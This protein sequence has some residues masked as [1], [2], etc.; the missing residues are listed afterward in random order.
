MEGN[1]DFLLEFPSNK[2]FN[3][4]A[5]GPLI[6]SWLLIYPRNRG[7]LLLYQNSANMLH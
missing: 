5:S 6:Y 7:C 1:L 4:A 2:F 3:N